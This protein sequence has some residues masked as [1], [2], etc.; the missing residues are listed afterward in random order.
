MWHAR[1]GCHVPFRYLHLS[2][3]PSMLFPHHCFTMTP[4]SKQI[5]FKETKIDVKRSS[6]H[7]K[8]SGLAT[9]AR[10]G[11]GED[12]D[13]QGTT[14]GYGRRTNIVPLGEERRLVSTEIALR[15]EAKH[16]VCQ[17]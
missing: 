16:K 1:T 12:E 10:H 5:S 7:R 14:T 11:K 17:K 6:T 3:L 2:T 8:V 15:K 9:A 4:V 13:D